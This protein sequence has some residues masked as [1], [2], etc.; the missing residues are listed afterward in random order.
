MLE[1]LNM[2]K[3]KKSSVMCVL[4]RDKDCNGDEKLRVFEAQGINIPCLA[5][6]LS[7]IHFLCSFG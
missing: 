3:T 6:L 5:S 1:R 2:D 4:N 7:L